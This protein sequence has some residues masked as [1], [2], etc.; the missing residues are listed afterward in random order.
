MLIKRIGRHEG[1]HESDIDS[2]VDQRIERAIE[3]LE[4]HVAPTLASY[5]GFLEREIEWIKHEKEI[6][7]A[8]KTSLP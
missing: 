1:I 4:E 6:R 8:L 3:Q 5:K 2:I 7:E